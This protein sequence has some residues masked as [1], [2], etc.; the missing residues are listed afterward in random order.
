MIKSYEE[1]VLAVLRLLPHM[2]RYYEMDS[3]TIEDRAYDERYR[4]VLNYEDNLPREL[5][6][7]F[8]PTQFVGFDVSRLRYDAP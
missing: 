4:H 6:L 2:Y 8:S 3:P 7:S 5:V 1:Y